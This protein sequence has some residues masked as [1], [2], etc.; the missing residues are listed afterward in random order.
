MNPGRNPHSSDLRTA[1]HEAAEWALRLRNGLR[2]DDRREFEAWLKSDVRRGAIFAEMEE[3]SRLLDRLRDPAFASA[4]VPHPEATFQA[5][6][7]PTETRRRWLAPLALAAAA[8]LAIVGVLNMTS[9][10]ADGSYSA[11]FVTAAGASQTVQLPDGSVLRLNTDSAVV[12]DYSANERRVRLKRGEAFFSVAKNPQRPFWVDAGAVSVRAVGTEF[13]VRFRPES[14]EVLVKEGK[15]SVNPLPAKSA[16]TEA[17]DPPPTH[18]IVAGEQAT[19]SLPASEA[20]ERPQVLVASVDAQRME[21][22]LAWQQGRLEF[23]D[24]PLADV[25][26][27]FNRYN[28]HQ[29]AIGD[30]SLRAEPFG[31]TFAPQ[32]YEA[33]LEVLEQSFGIVGERRGNETILR[34]KPTSPHSN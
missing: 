15:V 6:T 30:P 25:V 24:T 27:E 7:G 17:A 9:P 34:R 20:R 29:L 33:F 5:D 28:R 8:A 16:T 31:G 3:A 12:A 23:T 4:D 22:A 26:A 19:V 32:G 1:E 10:V 18:M 11:A 14:V 13:N 21:S 2:R